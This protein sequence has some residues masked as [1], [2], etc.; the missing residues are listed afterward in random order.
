VE[1][2]RR[3]V[4]DDHP[5]WLFW[6]LLPVGAVFVAVGVH[7]VFD[8]HASTPPM[9]VAR[10]FLGAG[11]A[12]D[13]LIAPVFV[14]F[15]W[16]TGWLPMVAR[17]PVRLAL[18]ASAVLTAFAWPLVQGYGL[19]PDNASVLPLDYTRNLVGALLAIWVA[20]GAAVIV[21]V[22]DGRRARA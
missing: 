3:V 19:S 2:Q 8:D 16:L 9:E 22:I 13:A 14:V 12:H 4:D 1:G 15:G 7:G 20:T 6:A 11:V 21:R 10:W 18:V 17:T 5:G